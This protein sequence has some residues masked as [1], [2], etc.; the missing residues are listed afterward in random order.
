MRMFIV[1][2]LLTGCVE[3]QIR[4]E[5]W[6]DFKPRTAVTKS[7]LVD[8]ALMAYADDIARLKELGGEDL[9][10]IVV[11]GNGAATPSE[12]RERAMIE[13]A[14]RGA[15][16]LLIGGEQVDSEVVTLRGPSAVTSRYG[17]TL[18]TTTQPEQKATINRHSGGYEAIRVD[19]ERWS[20]LP[21]GLRPVRPTRL[22]RTKV[23]SQ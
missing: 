7:R 9:G 2:L 15:T 10:M 1:A 18:V 17:D 22:P 8:K 6:A 5:T 11:R 21:D 4:P 23:V 13:A 12:L 16:H 14:V 20:E 19:P 3:A